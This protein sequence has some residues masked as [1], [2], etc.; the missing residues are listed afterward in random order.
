MAVV[1]EAKL[2]YLDFLSREDRVRHHRYVE[3]MKQYD[4]M[5]S[6]DGAAIAESVKLWD[7]GLYG[8]VCDD[9]LRNAKYLFVTS[10]TLATRFA[11]EG[12]MDE[13][14]AYNASD[15]YIQDVDRC[16]SVAEVRRMH[17]DMMTFFTWAMA[18]LQKVDVHSKA[19]A[20]CM[21]YI[22]Y[23]LHER[24][25]VAMLANHVHLN[26]T[27]L[28]ELF[29][30]ETGTS[31]SQYVTDRRME[32]AANMLRYSQYSLGE[33]AQIL[34]YSSQSHFSKVFKKQ[35]GVTPGEYRKANAQTG[36]WPE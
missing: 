34:A 26:P 1:E 30:K 14:D 7:S 20:E 19:V 28:S 16:E 17:T 12:G 8:H 2:R 24:I 29:S 33:I 15:L 13:E 21:D 11:I 4:L 23:H 3:E 27:Y 31:I 25:T 10:I 18:D 22:H 35:M 36:I 6:G 32:A 9:P 5:R